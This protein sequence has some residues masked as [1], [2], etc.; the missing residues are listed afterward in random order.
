M[1]FS[2]KTVTT[3]VRSCVQ[4]FLFSWGSSWLKPSTDASHTCC[5]YL[6][7]SWIGRLFGLS[8]FEPWT[9]K[10]KVERVSSCIEDFSPGRALWGRVVRLVWLAGLD[11]RRASMCVVVVVV[12]LAEASPSEGLL[13][14]LLL[15]HTHLFSYCFTVLVYSPCEVILVTF[16]PA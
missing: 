8:P 10:D 9:T 2:Q 11:S 6:H 5:I 12:L 16:K 7:C 4:Q 13:I 14:V 3:L 1:L 15:A